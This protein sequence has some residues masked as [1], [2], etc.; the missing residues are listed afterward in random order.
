MNARA[1]R[2]VV[3]GGALVAALGA[4]G[5]ATSDEP[6]L[7]LDALDPW[8]VVYALGLLTALGGVPFVLHGRYSAV[9]EDRD[10]RWEL[11]LSAWGGVA[12]VLAVGLVVLG[13]VL[14]FAAAS[15]SGAIVIVGLAACGLVVGGLAILVLST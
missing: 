15:A 8:L 2:L 12:L 14:G 6:H 11:A 3:L 10:R 4:L 13:L 1:A 7:S 9:T 5:V